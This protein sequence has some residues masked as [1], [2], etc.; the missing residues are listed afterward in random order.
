MERESEG[1]S[2]I[3][4]ETGWSFTEKRITDNVECGAF[5]KGDIFPTLFPLWVENLFKS[6]CTHCHHTIASDLYSI[7]RLT[8]GSLL[9]T[10]LRFVYDGYKV[11]VYHETQNKHGQVRYIQ[12]KYTET[13]WELFFFPS[14]PN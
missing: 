12:C 9:Y 1:L 4:F 5:I 2:V 11:C 14:R 6:I 3:Q 10:G 13:T 7:Q 8:N